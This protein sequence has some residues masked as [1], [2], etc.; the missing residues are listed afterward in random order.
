MKLQL[1]ENHA[2]LSLDVSSVYL[3]LL[4]G[5]IYV[6]MYYLPFPLEV[7]TIGKLNMYFS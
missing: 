4:L 7:K 1:G 6:H 3:Y 5:V 2:F